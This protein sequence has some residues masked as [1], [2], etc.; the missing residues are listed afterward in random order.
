[1]M[2]L[3]ERMQGRDGEQTAGQIVGPTSEELPESYERLL[4]SLL[5]GEPRKATGC[6]NA[7]VVTR[8]KI[9]DR[10]PRTVAWLDG[11]S[12]ASPDVP[13][14]CYQNQ[15]LGNGLLS[16]PADL[17]DGLIAS[18]HQETPGE[19]LGTVHLSVGSAGHATTG[20]KPCAHYWKGGCYKE[21]ACEF[22]HLCTQ[23]DFLRF[24]HT[25]RSW[26]KRSVRGSGK[27]RG[28]SGRMEGENATAPYH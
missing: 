1:M 25:K 21:S 16:D 9:Q 27:S 15:A 23:D 17:R 18:V 22:C 2:A 10:I 13:D 4:S 12:T 11:S 28:N 20:C 6:G 3:E 8:N 14:E 7:H 26:L 24:K 5:V 19:A